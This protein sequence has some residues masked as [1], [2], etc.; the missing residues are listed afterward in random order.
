M[1]TKSDLWVELRNAIKLVDE[2]YKYAVETS[3]VNF[4]TLYNTLQGVY[5]GSNVLAVETALVNAKNAFLGIM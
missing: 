2:S 1:A 5:T 4:A 3:S